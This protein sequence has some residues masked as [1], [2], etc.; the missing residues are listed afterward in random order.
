MV[1]TTTS[2]VIAVDQPCGVT[3]ESQRRDA[4]KRPYA[5]STVVAYL[6]LA[7]KGRRARCV[8]AV[9]VTHADARLTIP[10]IVW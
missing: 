10:R 2:R 3:Q 1:I 6:T 5:G 9:I 8:A 4:D 7:V